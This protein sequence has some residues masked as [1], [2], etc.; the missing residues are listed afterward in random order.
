MLT[1]LEDAT[2]TFQGQARS[3]LQSKRGTSSDEQETGSVI[4]NTR[5]RNE[6]WRARDARA[7]QAWPHCVVRR[8]VLK[9]QSYGQRLSGWSF[10]V[11]AN[12]IIS[13]REMN[14]YDERVT[15]YM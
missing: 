4:G 3:R 1:Y 6:R 2:V 8:G 11:R 9:P 10:A 12:E 7:Y 5:L 14:K 15:K 13:E